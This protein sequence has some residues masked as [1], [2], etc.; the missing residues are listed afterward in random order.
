LG[1]EGEELD[2]FEE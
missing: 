1:F 2:W